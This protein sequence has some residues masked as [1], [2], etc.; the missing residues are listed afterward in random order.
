MRR[1]PTPAAAV[2]VTAV[3]LFTASACLAG[4]PGQ[5]RDPLAA[6]VSSGPD[7][8][9]GSAPGL[10]DAQT[11]AALIN[12]ADLGAPWMPSEGAA[13]WRDGLLKATTTASPDCQRLLE[14][15]YT[16]E[17][18]G[19]PSGSRAVSALDDG[20]DQAQLRYQVAAHRPADVD[21]ALAWLRT[22]P[23]TCG[24]FLATTTSSGVETV[25]VEEL[26][27]PAVGDARQGLR[28]TLTGES[29][30]NGQ[31]PVLTLEV[32]AV[33]V[34]DEAIVLTDG[35]LGSVPPDDSTRRALELG[36]QRLTQVRA[37]AR[38]QA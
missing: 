26:L 33:R 13:T 17:P 16:E 29:D 11:R 20:D 8:G 2:A 28:V 22:L 3:T 7:T 9:A 23:S 35:A 37:Q 38:T 1:R 14:A 36:A 12:E 6:P 27:L 25:Q 10:T 30:M 15:L 34:A 4:T 19:R 24:Q 21:R 31:S 5:A 18:F 32:A